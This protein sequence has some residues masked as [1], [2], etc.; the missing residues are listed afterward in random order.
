MLAR[1][2]GKK[3]VRTP[4]RWTLEPRSHQLELFEPQQ[5]LRRVST[6][7]VVA[8]KTRVERWAPQKGQLSVEVTPFAEIWIDGKKERQAHTFWI[9]EVW[10]GTHTVRV[11]NG[12]LNATRTQTVVVQPGGEAKASFN[13][14]SAP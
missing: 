4:G 2:D 10:E 11:V 5:G 14:Q 8:G 6:V 12:E 7:T 13:L 3:P 9:G 1:V